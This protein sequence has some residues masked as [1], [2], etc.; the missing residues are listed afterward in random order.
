MKIHPAVVPNGLTCLIPYAE[1]W[2]DYLSWR[3]ETAGPLA[4]DLQELSWALEGRREEIEDWFYETYGQKSAAEEA[5]Y[6]FSQL[7]IMEMNEAN[8]PGI[9]SRLQWAL[10]KFKER[11]SAKS[12]ERLQGE[13][14]AVRNTSP[15]MRRVHSSELE[16]T[17]R[18]LEWD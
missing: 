8:G 10:K 14:L 1:K 11:P 2:G 18:L 7:L 6:A 17:V 5:A 9:S 3:P 13:V 16:E 12:R 4:A 15:V